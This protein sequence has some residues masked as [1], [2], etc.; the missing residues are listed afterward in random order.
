MGRKE[1]PP[2]HSSH[3]LE[4][5]PGPTDLL[6]KVRALFVDSSATASR[7]QDAPQKWPGILNRR[8]TKL[9]EYEKD[10]SEKL[11]VYWKLS[12]TVAAKGIT[13]ELCS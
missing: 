13:P 7:I 1:P 9:E 3:G 11:E 10:L 4:F 12:L 5:V 6:Q 8:I 2:P